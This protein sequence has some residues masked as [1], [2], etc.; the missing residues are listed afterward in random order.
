[1]LKRT[2]GLPTV[3][4]Y[5]LLMSFMEREVIVLFKLLNMIVKSFQKI[6]RATVPT[7]RRMIPKYTIKQL[8]RAGSV[9]HLIIRHQDFLLFLEVL[10]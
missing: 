6:K 2:F 9:R 5:I 8:I 10:W 4:I 1:M 7:F 3:L